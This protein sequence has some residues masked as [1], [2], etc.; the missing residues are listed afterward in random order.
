MAPRAP[1]SIP[2]TAA[3]PHAHFLSTTSPLVFKTL[4]KLSRPSLLSL[5][6]EWLRSSN[7]TSCAPFLIGDNSDGE[8]D[9]EDET[10]YP[11]AQS[12]EELRK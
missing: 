11:A 1:L 8:N 7:Q 2:T 9:G 10:A 6:L 5:V 12:L 4:A 3:L